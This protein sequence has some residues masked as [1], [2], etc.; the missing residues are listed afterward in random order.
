MAD[1]EKL[2][3]KDVEQ[4]TG[5]DGSARWN[6]RTVSGLESGY[7]AVRTEPSYD[8]NELPGIELHNGDIVRICSNTTKGTDVNGNPCIYVYV[9]VENSGVSG[10]V[11]A[12]FLK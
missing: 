7:L 5:G 8:D 9:Y 12:S 4:A 10:Y 2:D 6:T 3:D 1:F 11:N